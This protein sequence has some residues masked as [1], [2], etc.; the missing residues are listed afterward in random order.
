[1][2]ALSADRFSL[3]SGQSHPL[4]GDYLGGLDAHFTSGK[5]VGSA[6]TGSQ[7]TD[8]ATAEWKLCDRRR[9]YQEHISVVNCP[10]FLFWNEFGLAQLLID[11]LIC[12]WSPL[13]SDSSMFIRN[14]GTPPA[15]E[16][17]TRCLVY[18]MQSVTCREIRLAIVC[19]VRVGD[20]MIATRRSW[21]ADWPERIRLDFWFLLPCKSDNFDRPS[22]IR[23]GSWR[24][25]ADGKTQ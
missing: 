14:I 3:P 13:C 23:N 12:A 17:V 22:S 1:M 19:W 20:Q 16:S 10:S 11:M 8:Y 7:M 18:S 4:Q 24:I 15:P 25:L 5:V 9:V 2:P 6:P 21:L